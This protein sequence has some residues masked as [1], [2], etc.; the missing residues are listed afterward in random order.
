MKMLLSHWSDEKIEIDGHNNY[1]S[2]AAVQK[3]LILRFLFQVARRLMHRPMLIYRIPGLV[4]IDGIP[5]SDDERTKADLYFMEQQ[6]QWQFASSHI[7]G[8]FSNKHKNSF[9]QECIPVECVRPACC[10]YLPACTAE[11]CTW[12]GGCTW[13]CTWSWGVPGPRE[14]YL[15]PGVYLVQGVYL[16]QG[17]L[18]GPG[19]C[20]CSRGVPVPGGVQNDT[21]I[22]S[23]HSSG[24]HT[25]HSSSC[26]S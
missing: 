13:R 15:V 12:S 24:M 3:S 19:G 4:I 10:P 11:G 22:T 6:V 17:G 8:N 9:K 5:V 2:R 20:T 21:G 26:L 7:V 23:M 25:V 16:F 1:H 14:V 18:P